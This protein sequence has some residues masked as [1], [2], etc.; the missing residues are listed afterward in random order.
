MEDH[1]FPRFQI[2]KFHNGSKNI[3]SVV[4]TNDEEEYNKWLGKWLE[5]DKIDKTLNVGASTPKTY[6]TPTEDTKMCP[7]HNVK[8][9]RKEGKYGVYYSHGNKEVGYCNGK[10]KVERS[11]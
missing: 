7:I 3:Q 1:S 11:Y 6:G 5:E 2:S 4:R 10:P 8:M 9:Y